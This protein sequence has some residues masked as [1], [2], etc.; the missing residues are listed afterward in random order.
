[1]N[2][3]VFINHWQAEALIVGKLTLTWINLRFSKTLTRSSIH[4]SKNFVEQV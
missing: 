2:V 3:Q 4:G 1:M